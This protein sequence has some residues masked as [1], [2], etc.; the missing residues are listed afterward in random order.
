M[1]GGGGARN[2]GWV[3]NMTNKVFLPSPVSLPCLSLQSHTAV[4]H[5]RLWA[6]GSSSLAWVQAEPLPCSCLGKPTVAPTSLVC[7]MKV[8]DGLVRL[9]GLFVF[10]MLTALG[11][12]ETMT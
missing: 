11:F 3:F 9:S 12:K 6:A 10:L 2:D 5:T 7:E 8:S 1:P 4:L